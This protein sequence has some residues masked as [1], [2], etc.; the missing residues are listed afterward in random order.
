MRKDFS[1]IL[2]K[3]FKVSSVDFP[4]IFSTSKLSGRVGPHMRHAI[5]NL[6][7]KKGTMSVEIFCLKNAF[8]ESYSLSSF[9][10]REG[11]RTF[12]KV[13]EDSFVALENLSKVLIDKL[14]KSLLNLVADEVRNVEITQRV[15]TSSPQKSSN[16]SSKKTS[17]DERLN[18]SNNKSST[19]PNSNTSQTRS[20][21]KV[22]NGKV[23]VIKVEKSV[24]KTSEEVKI[25]DGHNV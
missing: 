11:N 17:K 19:V 3:T 22:V 7:L 12:G 10:V 20:R 9:R 1:K 2:D 16:V 5:T 6:A 24:Q 23:E 13:F 25:K 4:T 21:K 8:E 18:S 14:P 15:K